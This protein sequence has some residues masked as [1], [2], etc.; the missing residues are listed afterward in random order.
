MHT[1]FIRVTDIAVAEEKIASWNIIRSVKFVLLRD[2]SLLLY[3][4]NTDWH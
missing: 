2:D 4:Y 1:V 3:F